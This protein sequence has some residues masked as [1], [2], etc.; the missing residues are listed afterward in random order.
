[1]RTATSKLTT[2]YQATIPAPVREVLKVDAGDTIAFDI[3]DGQIRLRKARP[4]DL[5]FARA[6]ESTL[7]E[8]TSEADEEA[9]RDL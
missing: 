2:K 1:M 5:E 9:Y 8:W 4:L 6:L 3:D 7:S